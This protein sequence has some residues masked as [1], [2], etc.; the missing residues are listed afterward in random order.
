[1]TLVMDFTHFAALLRNFRFFLWPHWGR[2]G[3]GGGHEVP[4]VVG[5][6]EQQRAVDSFARFKS[7][8]SDISKLDGDVKRAPAE[9]KGRRH[10]I[11]MCI[12]IK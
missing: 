6:T 1:M 10:T 11:K 3:W 8:Q 5:A 7:A 2:G 4:C 12:M 9:I